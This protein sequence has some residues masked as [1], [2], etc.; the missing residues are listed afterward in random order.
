MVTA[1]LLMVSLVHGKQSVVVDKKIVADDRFDDVEV[2]VAGCRVRRQI[3]SSDNANRHLSF[4]DFSSNA[5]SLRI[6][7]LVATFLAEGAG[8]A[9]EYRLCATWSAPE[10][11]D[12]IVPLLVPANA[13][14][15]FPGYPTSKFQLDIDRVWPLGSTPVFPS[16][17][18]TQSGAAGN[19]REEVRR[20][21]ECFVIEIAL[22]TATLDLERP[23]PMEVLLLNILTKQI[24]IGRYPNDERRLEDVA[25]LAINI[26]ATSRVFGATL[27]PS[28]TARRL[29]LRTDFGRV[30][31]AFPL[32]RAVLQE[33]LPL[34]AKLQGAIAGGG[35]HLVLAGPGAG[36]SWVLT[37]LAE[38]LDRQ[39]LLVA[40]HYCFL[41]PG[42]DQVE[43]RVTTNVFFGN[44]LG[45][46]SDALRARS[47]SFP[48]LFSA[49]IQELEEFFRQVEVSGN[50]VVLIVDGLD[51]IAR[52]V[53]ASP[54]LCENEA[55]IIE[56]LATLRLP[57][58][59]TL[60]IGSQPGPHLDP[61]RDAFKHRVVEHSIETWSAEE[62]TSFGCKLGV[63]DALTDAGIVDDVRR[64]DIFFIL[65]MR[66]EG[67]PLYARY[68]CRG[69]VDGL[70]SA[71][72][73]DPGAWLT[74]A[75]EINGDIALYY[76]YLYSRSSI[77]AQAIAD[78]FGVLDFSVS[79]A[80]LR[81]IVGSLLE[82]WVPGA[83]A[84]L[85]PILSVATGQ[86]GYRIFHESF[87]RFMLQG[88]QSK[89]RNLA[90]VL[91][92][93]IA[94]LS[95]KGVYADAR[96]YRF[97][98]AALRRAGKDAE[99][100][101]IVST[102]FAHKSVL[103]GHP[104]DAIERNLEIASDVAARALD[105]PALLRF[106]ELTRAVNSCFDYGTNDWQEYWQTYLLIH[107]PEALA[108]RLLFDG[109]PTIARDEG[110]KACALVDRAGAAAPWREYL[111]LPIPDSDDTHRHDVD[112]GA[113]LTDENELS[114]AAILGRLR[115]GQGFRIVRRV[116]THL[117]EIGTDVPFLFVRRLATLLA[118]EI[119]TSIVEAIVARVETTTPARY[120]ISR[121]VACALLLGLADAAIN[122]EN[123]PGA[124]QYA[125]HALLQAESPEEAVWCIE[126]GAAP[127]Y[128]NGIA[129]TITEPEVGLGGTNHVLSAPEVR[130][131]VAQVRLL[132]F[133]SSGSAW[134]ASQAGRL[135]GAGWY[136]CWLRYVIALA[137]AETLATNSLP[138]DIDGAF[139]ELIKDT[140]PFE[141]TPRACDLYSIQR[142]I[143]ESLERGLRLTRTKD[144]FKNAIACISDARKGTATTLDREDGGPISHYTFLMLLVAHAP[145]LAVADAV[146]VAMEDHLAEAEDR[147]TYYGTHA[148][149]RMQMA[150]LHACMGQKDRALEHWHQAGTFLL[151]YGFHKD[152]TLFDAIDSVPVL[153]KYST[154]EALDALTALE[155]LLSSVLLHTDG[156][157]TKNAPSAWFR[158]LIKVDPI[159]S[160]ELLCR[161]YMA[162]PDVPYWRAE[163][164]MKD[165]LCHPL[166]SANPLLVDALWET[167]LFDIAYENDGKDMS[168]ERLA[169][170]VRI[171]INDP[172]YGQ[173]RFTR[174]CAEAFDDPC[175]HREGALLPLYVFALNNGLVWTGPS[176]P[177]HGGQSKKHSGAAPSLQKRL[178]EFTRSTAFPPS[179]RLVD[180][181]TYLRSFSEREATIDE[182]FSSIAAPM[183]YAMS[184]M[185]DRGQEDQAVRLLYFLVHETPSFSFQ[186]THPIAHL[187]KCLDAAGHFD[188][189]TV[190]YTLAFTSS[191]GGGGWLNFG[192][193][194]HTE[195]LRRAIELDKEKAFATLANETARKVRSGGHN[196]IA[197]HLVEQI[198]SWGDFE[199]AASA[200]KEAFAVIETRLPLPR[201]RTVF[202][203]LDAKEV[204][205]WSVNEA[206]ATLLLVRTA[207]PA[208]PRRIAAISGFSRLLN[209]H[210][211][212][213][214]KPVLWM[215]SRD[216][217]VSTVQTILQVLLESPANVD[218]ILQ[219]SED[220]LRGYANSTSW[221]LS[222]LAEQLLARLGHPLAVTRKG[223]VSASTPSSHRGK[224]LAVYGDVPRLLPKLSKLWPDLF[225]FVARRMQHVGAA[226]NET[227]KHHMRERLELA[228][229]RHRK[230][231]PPALVLPWSSELLI[232]V[233]DET[234]MAF[235][236][237]LWTSGQW[238]KEVVEFMFH[239]MLSDIQ[240]HTALALSRI[241]RPAWRSAV[242]GV[243]QVVSPVTVP[244]DDPFFGGWVRL[245]MEEVCHFQSDGDKYEPADRCATFRSG[246]VVADFAGTVPTNASPFRGGYPDD[247]WDVADAAEVLADSRGAQ[248][249]KEYVCIDWLGAPILLIPP[250]ILQHRGKL[251]PAS[252][253]APLCWNDKFGKPAVVLRTWRVRGDASDIEWHSV[254]GSDLLVR[255]DMYDVLMRACDGRLKEIQTFEVSDAR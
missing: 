141:G 120:S 171:L 252:Q 237:H 2:N 81:E 149:F 24:G 226:D 86:N 52:V 51:H 84:A 199:V 93:V 179:T 11:S 77:E 124:Q 241:A 85:S 123:L 32:D 118:E 68:L 23:G 161:D 180:I 182:P 159:R 50:S 69:L 170:L 247:W 213:F 112:P 221:T 98:F 225:E 210:A 191:R 147:G 44:L 76:Q 189:A 129:G 70:L 250:L 8:H 58:A 174:L 157:E 176:K 88:L 178:S 16:L 136:R 75:P 208:L 90:K 156:R 202:E 218:A 133:S 146:V 238:D 236:E 242:D 152:I 135:R 65:A 183:S 38:D 80:D 243:N 137:Q 87:R 162:S 227:F 105:W 143:Q 19:T 31:Q 3:K 231:N 47:L 127:H 115:I 204:V 46:L 181:L 121:P 192:D 239:A 163:Q 61:L 235:P 223:G 228:N 240:L 233:L 6:D 230:V 249:V 119:S 222:M 36:K 153:S 150:R 212:V 59:I 117:C 99:I 104:I 190:A 128:A 251:I 27:T 173:E 254:C 30:A 175:Q 186:R 34:R 229:G 53:G 164:A 126:R 55:D 37:Q 217:T 248:L 198:A 116:Y 110:L 224:M 4:S 1:Y 196:G 92:P 63:H 255:P 144:E 57:D 167:I 42:D 206:L 253:G 134:L 219:A 203:P 188:L 15:S 43:H 122:A 205:N 113:G 7:R 132:S 40:R 39:G 154:N 197:K 114:L 74:S 148:E 140:R 102:C 172:K 232:S 94:W 151:G 18:A 216:S 20:F 207:S 211:H 45:E 33:R 13:P 60:V 109:R 193:R 194:N 29:S 100:L 111:A 28:E 244:T 96:C 14:D 220:L 66:S 72:I 195:L 9:N 169:P 158:S 79:E 125:T 73:V 17:T 184:E 215:L 78:V 12:K 177:L 35:V 56:Q 25:A 64:N 138:Y 200:W 139:S 165:I 246:V 49:G 21:C 209:A 142:V 214:R 5:V 62:V 155:P 187:A 26:A 145:T 234:M 89:G 83:L 95:A 130:R 71:D 103:H 107:G 91:E 10:V 245:A 166:D 160:I 41:E 168:E 108:E 201:A 54:S 131:W 22:P 48:Q 101:R 106:A 97:L 185:V 82:D 67:N